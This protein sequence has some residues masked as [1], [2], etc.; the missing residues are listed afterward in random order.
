VNKKVQGIYGSIKDH[1]VLEDDEVYL[2]R[3]QHFG[4]QYCIHL[5]DEVGMFLRNVG[6]HG[7]IT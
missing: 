1:G 2:D 4:G 5:V 3:Y 6:N 7:V